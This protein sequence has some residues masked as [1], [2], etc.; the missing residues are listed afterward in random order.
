MNPKQN[1]M[2][3]DFYEEENRMFN[4]N[5]NR[6]T[7]RLSV[8]FAGALLV[9]S[10]AK[11]QTTTPENTAPGDT[12]N[13]TSIS[14]QPLDFN[15]QGSDSGTISGLNTVHFD[16]DSSTLNA[17]T[18]KQL[19]ENATWIKNNA[20]STVQIEGHTDERGSIEYN[21][22]LG[23]RRAKAVK[24]YLVGLGVDA[25]KMTVISFGKEKKIA[26]GDSEEAHSKNRRA[27]FVP[28]KN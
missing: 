21:L 6:A 20:K 19:A 14:S 17:E 7:R 26:D 2:F 1:T 15:P 3:P 24:A 27:N 12:T 13:D 22:A 4:M 5:C 23:E 28:L 25:K 9:I 10:C 16:Y 18:K 8:L 11:K